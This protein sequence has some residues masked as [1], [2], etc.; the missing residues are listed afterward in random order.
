MEGD[1]WDA[2]AS[3][4]LALT[5]RAGTVSN[6]LKR[7]LAIG[8]AVLRRRRSHYEERLRSLFWGD[9]LGFELRPS[10]TEEARLVDARMATDESAPVPSVQAGSIGMLVADV[11][12]RAGAFLPEAASFY[13]LT[14]AGG[15]A[16]EEGVLLT[17]TLQERWP[18]VGV[19]ARGLAALPED[20]KEFFR[21][22]LTAGG[23][24]FI[25]DL[26]PG[27]AH[28][29]ADIGRALEISLPLCRQLPDAATPVLFSATSPGLTR[30]FAGVRV[31]GCESRTFFTG[32]EKAGVLAWL[33]SKDERLPALVEI[34]IGAGHLVLSAGNQRI[35]SSLADSFG[36]RRAMAVLPSMMLIRR[37]YG[38]AAWHPPATLAN[39]TIDDPVL[40]NGLLGLDYRRAL[41]RARTHGFHL[42][43]ATIPH[44][45]DLTEPDVVD[46]LRDNPLHLSACY[47]G[48]EHDGYEFYHPRARRLRWR[49]RP[50]PGQ[51][52]ALREALQHAQRLARTT[53][54]AL[55]RVMVFPHGLGPVQILPT[56][57]ELGFLAT[58]NSFDRYPLGGLP[59]QDPDVGMR[60]ADLAWAG[61]PL[62][63]RRPLA[64]RTFV[65]DLFAG[66]P[67]IA[68][69]HRGE[70]GRDLVPFVKRAEAINQIADGRAQWRGLEEI[71]R[72]CYV[73]RR[74]PHLG[75]QVRMLGNEICL[76]NPDLETRVYRVQ[77]P[78]LPA[79]T[80]MVAAGTG[81]HAADEL[82]VHVPARRTSLVRLSR[83]PAARGTEGV[84]CS[85]LSIQK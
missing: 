8:L 73:Q 31:D 43:I 68:F 22:F 9:R 10:P 76:H 29:L 59:P 14:L 45:L 62:I 16:G 19:S 81:L 51:E 48:N 32:T 49:E 26:E 15:V 72:H 80:R 58:C 5:S 46:L 82:M 37:L 61:F 17:K 28:I 3:H 1:F 57:A 30:E 64:D 54:Y 41:V 40:R 4:V 65:F 47:H 84:T 50:L 55:D 39:F 44:D 20:W 18:L 13:G 53:G 6:R 83:S 27:C 21:R 70:V 12:T 67:A 34:R 35:T 56:L 69:A 24:L 75:W 25:H 71:A 11:A 2:A 74:D 66:R 7:S 63:W 38:E 33:L 85:I 52:R 77:R 36:P 42:T 60:P 23:T 78:R 79:G